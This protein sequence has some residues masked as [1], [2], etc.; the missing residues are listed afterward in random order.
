[1]LHPRNR[2]PRPRVLELMDDTDL[3][4]RLA[5]DL[6]GW[7]E[8]LVRGH[9]DRCFTI[10]LRILGD[11]GDAEEVTQDAFVRAYRALAT[12][13]AVRIRELRVRGWLATIV[14]NLARNRLRRH[15]PPVTSLA[16]L[17]GLGVEP[18]AGPGTDP[19]VLLDR[20]VDQHRLAAAIVQLPERY[21]VP[22][23]LRHVDELSYDEVAAALDRPVGTV[24][25]QVH[26]GL[27][28]LRL[29]LTDHE[30]QELTA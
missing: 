11:A 1:M 14:A 15:R 2:G 4:A 25:A 8:A 28:L 19:E 24:K 27:A 22:V 13:D 10:A 17:V 26:R 20:H 21:R 12:Y 23:V 7:F 6:D 16:P 30:P 18:V 29:A 9:V 5:V 3:T